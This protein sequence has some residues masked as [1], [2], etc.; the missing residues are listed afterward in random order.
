MITLLTLKVAHL[1]TENLHLDLLIKIIKFY[2]ILYQIHCIINTMKK[3][4]FI[5]FCYN[6]MPNR[7][8][9]VVKNSSGH[10]CMLTEVALPALLTSQEYVDS[11]VLASH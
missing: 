11:D 9:I 5:R 10:L 1:S 7:N 6:F 8:T 2:K 3:L 4:E